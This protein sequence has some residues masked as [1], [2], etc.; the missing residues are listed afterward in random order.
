[1][2]I[3][4]RQLLVVLLLL[5]ATPAHADPARGRRMRN[6]GAVLLG[7]ACFLGVVQLVGVGFVGSSLHD[8]SIGRSYGD[9]QAFGGLMALLTTPFIGMLGGGGVALVAVG[10][11]EMEGPRVAIRF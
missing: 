2:A 11:H 6:G 8:Q 10:D 7:G 3:A 1:V 9:A 5:L 4:M